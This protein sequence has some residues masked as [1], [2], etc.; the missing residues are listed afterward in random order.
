VTNWRVRTKEKKEKA[1]RGMR[2]KKVRYNAVHIREVW[3]EQETH[4]QLYM[5]VLVKKTWIS[6]RD[7]MKHLDHAAVD[8][9]LEAISLLPQGF[10]QHQLPHPIDAVISAR[11]GKVV[12][13][14]S[15]IDTLR[16][17]AAALDGAVALAQ[18]SSLL[19]LGDELEAKGANRVA[20]L[21]A[22]EVDGLKSGAEL[23]RRRRA[24]ACDCV[25]VNVDILE[26]AVELAMETE[27]SL[28]VSPSLWVADGGCGNS[29]AVRSTGDQ[30]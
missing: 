1:A 29:G 24:W 14:A 26:S 18:T 20:F 27:D 16:G 30:G 25:V 7:E 13:L 9:D 17:R 12:S 28:G 19:A 15:A 2:E 3:A 21:T 10:G 4:N 6:E 22:V 8:A 23:R 5:L 11:D